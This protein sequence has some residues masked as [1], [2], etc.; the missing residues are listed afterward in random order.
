MIS[1]QFW[2]ESEN[3]GKSHEKRHI[4]P[5]FPKNSR[6]MLL[7]C[8]LLPILCLICKENAQYVGKNIEIGTL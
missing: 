3:I 4:A 6:Q 8:V 1:D 2:P 5:I 7:L